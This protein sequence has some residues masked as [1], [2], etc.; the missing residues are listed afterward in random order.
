MPVTVLIALATIITLF[1]LEAA[2]SEGQ[3]GIHL[4]ITDKVEA[5]SAPM[6]LLWTTR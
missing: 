4:D 3:I 6:N 2:L 5:V 1:L